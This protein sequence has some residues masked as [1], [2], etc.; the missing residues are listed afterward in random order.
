MELASPSRTV[1]LQVPLGLAWTEILQGRWTSLSLLPGY[2][3]SFCFP[4]HLFKLIHLFLWG[5]CTGAF[6]SAEVHPLEANLQMYPCISYVGLYM[7]QRPQA[8]QLDP[9]QNKLNLKMYSMSTHSLLPSLVG[10]QST[11]RV[12][13]QDRAPWNMYTDGSQHWLLCG[14]LLTSITS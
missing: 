13:I 1:Y 9:V 7:E 6:S 12:S 4:P 3:T 14:L 8:Q 2:S 11:R 5:V 10:V